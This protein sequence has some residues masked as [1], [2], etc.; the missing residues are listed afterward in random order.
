MGGVESNS[1]PKGRSKKFLPEGEARGEEFFDL[2]EGLEFD[3][4]PPNPYGIEFL[5]IVRS[6]TSTALAQ[7]HCLRLNTQEK[8]TPLCNN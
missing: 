3:S 2:P 1:K 8:L 4:T 7:Y 6:K 5:Y